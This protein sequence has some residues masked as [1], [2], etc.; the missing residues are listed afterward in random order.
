MHFLCSRLLAVF[1]FPFS[2]YR[3]VTVSSPGVASQYSADGKVH[4]FERAMLTQCLHS[5]LAACGGKSARWRCQWR[6]ACLIKPYGQNQDLAQ[7]PKYGVH[8]VASA[9]AIFSSRVVIL[10]A[11]NDDGRCLSVS[12]IK[13]MSMP[14]DEQAMISRMCLFSLYVSLI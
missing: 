4:A 5:I 1:R 2:R 7:K 6:Y 3:V 13:A 11:I 12:H 10:V 8:G 14:V 9:F